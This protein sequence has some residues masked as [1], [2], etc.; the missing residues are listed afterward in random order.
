MILVNWRD[1]NAVTWRILNQA[2]IHR[3]LRLKDYAD[4]KMIIE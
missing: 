1:Y 3:L 2:V 4:L